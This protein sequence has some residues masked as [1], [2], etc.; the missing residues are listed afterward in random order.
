MIK[1]HAYL[2]LLAFVANFDL[3]ETVNKPLCAWLD[4]IGNSERRYFLMLW[5]DSA[6]YLF[7]SITPYFK[8]GNSP[9]SC[10]LQTF[11]WLPL[12]PE[13]T[14]ISCCK[15]KEAILFYYLPLGS[16]VKSYLI[17]VWLLC[18]WVRTIIEP[19]Q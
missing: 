1:N 11:F 6:F 14:F 2:P 13:A 17:W 5:R 7:S 9:S 19:L 4:F 16:A 12:H 15:N 10:T 3:K 8:T 18:Y